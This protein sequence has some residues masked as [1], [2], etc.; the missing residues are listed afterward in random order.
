[1]IET[2]A[3]VTC[4]PDPRNPASFLSDR[5][6]ISL[7]G[8]R[9]LAMPRLRDMM[10][11]P[12]KAR[13]LFWRTGLAGDRVA[14]RLVTGE[15]I[16]LARSVY[17]SSN[18]ANEIFVSDIYRPPRTIESNSVN[19]IVDV[20]ANVGY[21][22]ALWGT[23]FPNARINAFEPHPYYAALLRQTVRL[24]HLI[25]RVTIHEAAVGIRQGECDLVNAGVRSTIVDVGGSAEAARAMGT[26]RVPVVDFFSAVSGRPIDLLKIDCEGAEYDL[27][28]DLRFADIDVKVLVMEWHATQAHPEADR[29]LISRLRQLGWDVMPQASETPDPIEGIG[30]LSVGILW[31]Y[32]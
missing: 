27:L 29:D 22:V 7:K 8:F 32:R 20:G 18:V 17:K 4:R 13:Y 26:T 24:N 19:L 16:V 23:R 10:T 15:R 21:S 9:A 12:S 30:I 5:I 2:R 1:M 28:M 31:A 14:V 3:S 11:V 25:K 6:S